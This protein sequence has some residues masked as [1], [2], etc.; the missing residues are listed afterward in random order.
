MSEFH[1][2]PDLPA[3]TVITEVPPDE[4][5]ILTRWLVPEVGVGLGTMVKVQVPEG[6]TVPQLAPLTTW[7]SKNMFPE[8]TET[9]VEPTFLRVSTRLLVAW[10]L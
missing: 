7:P 9:V 4:V 8:V 2:Y 3:I 6:A 10:K 5:R 1:L